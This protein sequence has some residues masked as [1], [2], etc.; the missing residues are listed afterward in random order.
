MT[1][2]CLESF[3]HTRVCSTASLKFE[4]F[5]FWEAELMALSV[6]EN[7]SKKAENSFVCV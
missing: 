5:F 3:W 2:C 6:V 7:S 1:L 4:G